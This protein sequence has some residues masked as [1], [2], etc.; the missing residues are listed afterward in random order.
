MQEKLEM[1]RGHVSLS[2]VHVAPEGSAGRRP[3]SVEA[4]W[5]S[6]PELS[7]PEGLAGEGSLHHWKYASRG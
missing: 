1:V 4:S 6:Q 5:F 7:V 3:P 2:C